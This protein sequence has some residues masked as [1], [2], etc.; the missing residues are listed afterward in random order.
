[1]LMDSIY[2]NEKHMTYHMPPEISAANRTWNLMG[3]LAR[4]LYNSNIPFA[5]WPTWD[6]VIYHATRHV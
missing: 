6:E 3:I 5:R 4:L 1:M 2:D